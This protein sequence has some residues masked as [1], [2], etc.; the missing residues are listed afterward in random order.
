MRGVPRLDDTVKFNKNSTHL[1]T[2]SHM[3]WIN[4]NSTNYLTRAA[5]V[6]E[7]YEMRAALRG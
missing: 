2:N 4:F 6:T 5:T 1:K 7:L 3:K